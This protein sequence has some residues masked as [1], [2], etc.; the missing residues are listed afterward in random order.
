MSSPRVLA[1]VSIGLS[2]ACAGGTSGEHPNVL[3]ISIDTLRADHLGCFGYHRD[4][5]PNIDKF[6]A[7]STVFDK[8][9]SSCIPTDPAYTAIYTGQHSITH[10]VVSVGGDEPE[11]IAQFL[12]E[13]LYKRG[14]ITAAV[15]DLYRHRK[16][17]V[18][19][20]D[21]YTY[22]RRE[23]DRRILHAHK[24][25]ERAIPL[26]N[27]L[28]EQEDFFFFV[29]YWDPHTP[30]VPP[31]EYRR[32]FY[33][34]NEEDPANKSMEAAKKSPVWDLY[35]DFMWLE[36]RKITD[37]EYL[38]AQYDSEIRY[39][40]EKVA[41][42]LDAL[43][44]AGLADETL[45]I[46]TSDHGE[47]VAE[48]GIW[49]DHV[50]LYES[51]I[52]VPL[53]MRHPKLPKKRVKETVQ[54]LDIAPTI[55][56]FYNL[57]TDDMSIEGKNLVPVIEGKEKGYSEVYLEEGTYQAKR[58]VRTDKYK[59]IKAI[60]RGVFTDSPLREL[61]DLEADPAEVNNL[62]EKKPE[63]AGELEAKL[64]AW[65]EAKIVDRPDPLMYQINKGFPGRHWIEVN[66]EEM[67]DRYG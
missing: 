35:R 53:M 58:G 64:H 1:L 47:N 44:H 25:N 32:L 15:D 52:H 67:K 43:D 39:A 22:P 9:I 21:W 18:R 2:G 46:L 65:T 20:Y 62:A 50:G 54:S 8:C 36:G 6:A 27:I 61:Y 16:W 13:T 48:H 56:G 66:A 28:K 12:P 37:A 10:G 33:D 41:E 31:K 5:S 59:F 55:F 24:V 30:Y 3:L 63:I 19:G 29:H 17:F 34:G 7:Q 57:P 38:M 45:V 60:D 26:L 42:L 23:A 40:D 51:V 11:P 4:T 14:I 49:C